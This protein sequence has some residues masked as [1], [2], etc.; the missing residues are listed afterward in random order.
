MLSPKWREKGLGIAL[1]AHLGPG[2]SQ[3][4]FPCTASLTTGW[5]TSGIRSPQALTRPARNTPSRS[6]TPVIK[7]KVLFDGTRQ[8]LGGVM[9]SPKWLQIESFKHPESGFTTLTTNGQ[10]ASGNQI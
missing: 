8:C 10:E 4:M 6:T 2:L 5:E 9:L 7:E 3:A 1:V